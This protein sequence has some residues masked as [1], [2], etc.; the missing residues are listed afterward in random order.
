MTPVQ[1]L[2]LGIVQG[3]TEF[4]PVSSS[5]H[6]VIFQNFFRLS[7]PPIF[8][9]IVVH[10]GTLFAVIIYF[11]NQIKK[12]SLNLFKL[13]IAG[14]IP[15]VI[16]GLYIEPQIE[17]LFSSLT[18]VALGLIITSALLFSTK[19]TKFSKPKKLTLKSSLII[20]LFQALAIIPGVSRSGATVASALNQGAGK[21]KAFYFS[22]LLSIPAITGALVLQLKDL[23]QI[24]SAELIPIIIGFTTSLITGL[25]ALKLLNII[26]NNTKLH[27]FGFY[28][29]TLA[30]T[31]IFLPIFF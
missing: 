28:T 17:S 13:V 2:I 19:F 8:F 14:T 4:L 5:G 10:V 27:L 26:I 22:F 11:F 16:F 1:A 23:N 24:N 31:L 3:L 30:A 9:D 21:Q 12:I 29:A 18:V 15:A 25:L 7:Q 20:G 6:L